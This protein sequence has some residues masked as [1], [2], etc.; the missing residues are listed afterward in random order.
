MKRLGLSSLLMLSACGTL[1]EWKQSMLGTEEPSGRSPASM[2]GSN[3][4]SVS[5]NR[6]MPGTYSAPTGPNLSQNEFARQGAYWNEKSAMGVRRN[7]DPWDGT[8]PANE[9]SLWSPQ[10]QDGFYFARNSHRKLGDLIVVKIEKDIN[11]ALNAKVTSIIGRT[12]VRQVIADEAGRKIAEDVQG[13]VGTA[14][15]NQRIGAAIGSE[16]GGRA[17]QALDKDPK[18]L[19]VDEMSVRIVEV[20]SGTHYKIDGT[21]N[22][23]IK[24]APYVLR[25]R[26]QIRDE[27]V[28]TVAMVS[29]NQVFESRMDL[30][31]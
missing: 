18:Y 6:A 25:L 14:L 12:G 17:T 29:S 9:G 3:Q 31:K 22:V 23:T 10:G 20:V 15:G 26:G 24:G 5:D 30:I 21:K 11:Q 27:D 28:A 8:G 2:G 13:K 19:D 16:V 7:A 1:T 4:V